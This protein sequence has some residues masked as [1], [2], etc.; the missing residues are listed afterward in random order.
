MENLKV[1]LICSLVLACL[2]VAGFGSRNPASPVEFYFG[3]AEIGAVMWDDPVALAVGA[4][5]VPIIVVLGLFRLAALKRAKDLPA[6]QDNWVASRDL[7]TP[8]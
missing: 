8:Q 5:F 4:V 7:R 3:A 1:F 2:A 6:R